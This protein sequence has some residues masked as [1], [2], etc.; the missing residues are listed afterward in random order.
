MAKQEFD[1]DRDIYAYIWGDKFESWSHINVRIFNAVRSVWSYDGI[2]IEARCQGGG[3]G[4]RDDG[5]PEMYGFQWGAV[6]QATVMSLCAVESA[7]KAMRKIA[8]KFESEDLRESLGFASFA[9]KLLRA[10]GAKHCFINQNFNRGFEGAIT[11]SL[12][13]FTTP[14]DIY[15][16]LDALER[17]ALAQVASKSEWAA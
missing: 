15:R 10:A 17:A 6:P 9:S 3:S 8:R 13:C 16:E 14:E 2:W 4:Y 5:T 7:A 12:P 11:E 1:R